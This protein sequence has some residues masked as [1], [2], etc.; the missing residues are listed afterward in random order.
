M[1]HLATRPNDLPDSAPIVRVNEPSIGGILAA[2]VDKGMDTASLEKLFQLY[3]R[4]QDRKAQQEFAAAMAKFKDIC[5]PIP[6]GTINNQFKKVDRNGVMKPRLYAALED[7]EP[8]IRTPLSKCGLTYRWGNER[9]ENGVAS[10][11]CI[12]THIGGHSQ[13][14]HSMFPVDSSAGASPQQKYAAAWAYCK[15]HSLEHALGLV[16]CD[17]DT[18]GNEPPGET[19]TEEQALA[20]EGMLSDTGANV[21]SFCNVLRIASIGELPASRYEEAVSKIRERARKVEEARKAKAGG[22]K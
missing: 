3:E 5:P 19:I 16:T 12:V 15:R 22:G 1:S 20:L 9:V 7:I 21:A 4:D 2:A 11:D 13:L 18:D 17:E 10:L 6:K 8:V 14:A